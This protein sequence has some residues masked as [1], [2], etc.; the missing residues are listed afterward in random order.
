M[1][2]YFEDEYPEFNKNKFKSAIYNGIQEDSLDTRVDIDKEVILPKTGQY[3][4]NTGF[5]MGKIDHL[6]DCRDATE[7]MN[8]RN[9]GR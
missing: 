4:P 9:K 3:E 6:Q 8:N 5:G 2:R 1:S 7:R